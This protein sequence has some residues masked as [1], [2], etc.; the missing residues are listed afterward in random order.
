MKKMLKKELSNGRKE[1][2]RK[3]KS[4]EE[5]EE[6]ERRTHLRK[7]HER[8]KQMRPTSLAF[9]QQEEITTVAA[10]C[11]CSVQ[12]ALCNVQSAEF[13]ACAA[14]ARRKSERK[15]TA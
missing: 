8:E 5:V 3:K 6:E 12:C 7:R 10:V 15:V 14:T 4:Q 2:G 13:D 9:G 1:E 11:W